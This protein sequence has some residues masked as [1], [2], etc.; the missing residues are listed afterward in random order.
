M[1]RQE[2]LFPDLERPRRS[3][4]RR[5]LGRQ[6]EVAEGVFL[7]ALL[8]E[9][10]DD[11]VRRSLEFFLGEIRNANTRTAYGRAV[12]AFLAWCNERDLE[13]EDIE[14]LH[15]AG[16]VEQLAGELAPASVKQHLSAVRRFWR[17]LL[18]GGT[19]ASDPT[20]PVKGPRIRRGEGK[21]PV[22]SEDDARSILAAIDTSSVIGL[23]DRALL[24]LMATSL[25]RV[26]AVVRMRV[27]DFQELPDGARYRLLEKG[28]RER[29]IE[30][31]P[32]TEK[33]LREYLDVAGLLEH[34]DAA[35]FQSVD[36]AGRL[37]GRPLGARDVLRMTKRRAEAVGIRRELVTNHT[38][39]ATGGTD[40]MEKGGDLLTLQELMGHVSPETTRGYVRTP[41]RIRRQ[42]IMRIQAGM[43]TPR[44]E[45]DSDAPAV[46]SN[47]S[48]D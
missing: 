17:Y 48:E 7:P 5:S 44:R 31:H 32:E 45:K 20:A 12:A 46:E 23:R 28:G 47:L 8:A 13:L 14:P 2:T 9:A 26:G 41:P 21:T 37:T 29:R 6:V 4:A 40:Y 11:V 19:V 34:R 10:G 25:A 39:R 1:E 15:V 24:S 36:Q 22:L 33:Y 27:A 16:Y 38:W 3:L 42:E 43:A 30:A 35:L 18:V